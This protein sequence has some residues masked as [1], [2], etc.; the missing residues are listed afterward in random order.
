MGYDCPFLGGQF[1]LPSDLCSGALY[2][3]LLYHRRGYAL[4]LPPPFSRGCIRKL[5]ASVAR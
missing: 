2:L 3:N 5:T 1:H 4:V